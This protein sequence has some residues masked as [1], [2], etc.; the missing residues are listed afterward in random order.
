MA[1]TENNRAIPRDL[2]ADTQAVIDHLVS[3]KLLDPKVARRVQERAD[4]IREEIRQKHG[5]LD[6][7]EPAIRELRDGQ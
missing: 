1:T 7:G 5:V 2:L 6:I 4:R 3:G